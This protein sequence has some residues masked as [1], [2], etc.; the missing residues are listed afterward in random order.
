MVPAIPPG[1]S[2]VAFAIH[3]AWPPLHQHWAV[4][5]LTEIPKVVCS[6]QPLW[7]P[8]ASPVWIPPTLCMSLVLSGTMLWET[9]W[10]YPA[11]GAWKMTDS[12]FFSDPGT[13]KALGTKPGHPSKKEKASFSSYSIGQS[14][15]RL[16]WDGNAQRLGYWKAWFFGVIKKQS[17]IS[18]LQV[19]LYLQNN[20]RSHVYWASLVAQMV[21]NLRTMQETWVR[22][23]G[24]EDSLKKGMATHFSILAWE[25]H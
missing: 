20:A 7:D 22:S 16:R 3:C 23:L 13:C 4:R 15:Y 25:F 9:P 12:Q 19:L 18:I 10:D 1:P 6:F 24:W 21:K 2:T 8:A 11:S 17:I 14:S 5:L